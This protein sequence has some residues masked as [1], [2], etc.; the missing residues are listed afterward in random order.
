[1][2]LLS[3]VVGIAYDAATNVGANGNSVAQAVAEA[4]GTAAELIQSEYENDPLEA[5]VATG[6]GL[7]LKEI[8]VRVDFRPIRH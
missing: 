4:G 7:V 6:A 3:D 1:M 8:G 2:G 5:V